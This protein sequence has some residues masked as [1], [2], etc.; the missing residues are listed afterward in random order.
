MDRMEKLGRSLRMNGPC[1]IAA[2]LSGL[3]VWP[4]QIIAAGSSSH[5]IPAP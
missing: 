2:R 5:G 4:G 1:S 3:S